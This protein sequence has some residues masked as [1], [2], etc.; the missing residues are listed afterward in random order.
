MRH[1]IYPVLAAFAAVGSSLATHNVPKNRSTIT[2]YFKPCLIQDPRAS[3]LTNASNWTIYLPSS[4]PC[5]SGT[6]YVCTLIPPP[7]LNITT[8]T[9]LAAAIRANG[10]DIPFSFTQTKQLFCFNR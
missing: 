2:F 1:I 4:S 9:G 6:N 10:G 3:T 7:N 8:P 5:I